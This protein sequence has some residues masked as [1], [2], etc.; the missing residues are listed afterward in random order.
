[1]AQNADGYWL[2]E[3]R[4]PQPDSARVVVFIHGYGA[5]NPMV[6]GKWIAH[7]V[8]KGNIVIFPRYQAHLLYPLPNAFA[9]YVAKGIRSAL[10]ELKKAGHVRPIFEPLA[11]VGHSFGGAIAADLTIHYKKYGIPAPKAVFLCAPGTGFVSMG[12][13]STYA[14]MPPDVQLL[15]MVSEDDYVVGDELGVQIFK[16]ATRTPNRNLIRQFRDR[17]QSPGISAWHNESYSLDET[18]DAGFR[19]RTI[20]RALWMA[21]LDAV[22]FYGYWKFFDALLE[23]S[24]SGTWC[25]Y[26][27]GNTPEQRFAGHWPDGTPIK[28]F[29]IEVPPETAH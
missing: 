6:Y 26:A 1:Y 15:I 16:E 19:N 25:E 12:R 29:E 27:F 17:S 4:C 18:F 28:A 20:N 8:R 24:R 11:V 2:F 14:G 22:D 3:P 10:D 21:S 5:Y 23:C 9:D 13:L 7:L